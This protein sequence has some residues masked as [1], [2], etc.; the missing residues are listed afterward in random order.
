M[1]R[2]TFI[3]GAAAA[4]AASALPI[5]GTPAGIKPIPAPVWVADGDGWRL[6]ASF[7]GIK[8]GDIYVTQW[9]IREKSMSD[10]F[11]DPKDGRESIWRISFSARG[12]KCYPPYPWCGKCTAARIVSPTERF[13]PGEGKRPI[14]KKCISDPGYAARRHEKIRKQVQASM[15]QVRL[16]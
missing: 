7:L 13:D 5:P 14:C 9:P 4:A 16:G 12:P 10:G 3:Q 11:I 15:H 6:V 1:K 8:K 2:R